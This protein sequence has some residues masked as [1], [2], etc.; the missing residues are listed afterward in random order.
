MLSNRAPWQGPACH[1]GVFDSEP[2]GSKKGRAAEKNLDLAAR[3]VLIA[4]PRLY[5][6]KRKCITSPSWTT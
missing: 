1:G 6:L 3:A 4:R 2:H 5:T